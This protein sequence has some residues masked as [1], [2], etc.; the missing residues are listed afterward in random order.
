MSSRSNAVARGSAHASE[1][2]SMS[3][4]S[5]YDRR[6][7]KRRYDDDDAGQRLLLGGGPLWPA[8]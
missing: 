5:R 3:M 8:L 2:R 6:E 7:E 4:C 1:R